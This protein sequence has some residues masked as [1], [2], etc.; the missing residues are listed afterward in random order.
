MAVR[1]AARRLRGSDSDGSSAGLSGRTPEHVTQIFARATVSS[2]VIETSEKASGAAGDHRQGGVVGVNTGTITGPIRRAHSSRERCQDGALLARGGLVGTNG[3][4]IQE[5]YAAGAVPL[6]TILDE[7]TQ[8]VGGL[9]GTNATGST[10]TRSFWDTT[11]TGRAAG[12]GR[13]RHLRRHGSDHATASERGFF[14]PLAQGQGWNFNSI[15]A[16]PGGGFYPSSTPSRPSCA[17]SRTTARGSTAAPI[18][19]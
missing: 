5:S 2:N 13:I 12:A 16:P 11:A 4:N 8:F 19:P 6:D 10:V 15:W 17:L 7:G 9:V 3:G 14:V 1:S 18:P